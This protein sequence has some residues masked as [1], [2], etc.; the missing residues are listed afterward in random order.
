MAVNVRLSVR[1]S[2]S[3]CNDEFD[4]GFE[5]WYE[6]HASEGKY[7]YL[8]SCLNHANMA[9]IRNHEVQ[10]IAAFTVVYCRSQ[11]AVSLNVFCL[12]I[13]ILVLF[14][15]F[16]LSFFHYFVLLFLSYLKCRR[17]L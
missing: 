13:F 8:K 14:I 6:Q 2:V 3:R 12:F 16:C 15:L 11:F 17:S 10:T 7:Y 4:Y 5:T 1:M 9:A